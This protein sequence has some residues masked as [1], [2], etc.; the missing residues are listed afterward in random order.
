MIAQLK[1]TFRRPPTRA[2][3]DQARANY[4]AGRQ[5]PGVKVEAVIWRGTETELKRSIRS[6]A[7][8]IGNAGIVKQLADPRIT[9]S[10]LD[11]EWRPSMGLLLRIA[12]MLDTKI[13]WI[14]EDKTKNG[15]HMVIKWVRRFRPAEQIAIQ[16][17]LGS[18]REREAYNLARVLTGKRSNRWNLLFERKIL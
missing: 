6:H 9:L 7:A 14:R 15:W 11:G 4:V 18:D 8:Y 1:Y 13:I 12:R 16:C 10:D 5:T 17:I 3:L 2:L